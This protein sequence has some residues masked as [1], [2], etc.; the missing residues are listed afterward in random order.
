[1]TAQVSIETVV[2][3]LQTYGADPNRW[4]QDLRGPATTL[5][6]AQPALAA[7]AADECAL[8]ADIA[9]WPAH[10]SRAEARAA[11]VSLAR[12]T[13]QEI[14][15]GHAP[16]RQAPRTWRRGLVGASGLVAAGL[17]V[18]LVAA[19]NPIPAPAT[20]VAGTPAPAQV[21]SAGLV[22]PAPL[23]DDDALQMV[24]SELDTDEWL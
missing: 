2:E 10:S 13:P 3:L 4:P 7:I 11:I 19:P 24:F 21:V 20:V 18:A 1:M 14:A 8:D 9:G 15:P 22:S 12:V 17:A 6:A 5:L 23:T 16:S